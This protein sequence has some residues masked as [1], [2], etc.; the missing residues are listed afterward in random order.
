MIVRSNQQT[1][2]LTFGQPEG[3]MAKQH[4]IAKPDSVQRYLKIKNGGLYT[5]RFSEADVGFSAEKTPT[6]SISLNSR[7]RRRR[8]RTGFSVYTVYNRYYFTTTK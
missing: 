1:V 5:C 2:I 7:R 8:R 4:F 3:D 6:A